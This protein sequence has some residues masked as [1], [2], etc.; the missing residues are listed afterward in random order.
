MTLSNPSM[1]LR[2]AA[3][4][5]VAALGT[6]FASEANAA[7]F[8]SGVR[9]P[10]AASAQRLAASG[11]AATTADEREPAEMRDSIVGMWITDYLIGEGPDRYDQALQQFHSGGTETMLSNGLPPVLGNVCVGVWKAAGHG[12]F[13]LRHMAWNWT[14]D[15][16]FA[17]TFV[18][19]VTVTIDR[20]GRTFSGTWAA[21]S[22][23]PDG[24]LI[25]DLHAEGVV[26]AARVTVE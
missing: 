23:D 19:V 2:V 24:T 13:K 22:Y 11:S 9:S 10:L 25:E 21:D 12:T 5:A 26:E 15:G 18:M 16:S 14:E 20:G 7:C 17:G 3:A 6:T 1:R 4:I 8:A